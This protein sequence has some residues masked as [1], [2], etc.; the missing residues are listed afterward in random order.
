MIKFVAAEKSSD[1]IKGV[2]MV[3]TLNTLDIE[4]IYLNIRK[5][6]YEKPTA[7][8]HHIQPLNLKFFL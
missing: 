8:R 7:D 3:Q 2:F 5:A 1:N 4:G 6:V